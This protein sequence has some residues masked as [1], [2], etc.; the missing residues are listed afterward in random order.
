MRVTTA[1]VVPFLTES[2]SHVAKKSCTALWFSPFN[3]ARKGGIWWDIGSDRI[4]SL[5]MSESK[6]V[7]Y[8]LNLSSD[9][10]IYRRRRVEGL[11]AI[12]NTA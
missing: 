5:S 6:R 11:F 9:P 3:Q 2:D 7:V 10:S 4:L 12:F 1:R 8:P